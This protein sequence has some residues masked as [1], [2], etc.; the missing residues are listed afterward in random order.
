MVETAESGGSERAGDG[1]TRAEGLATAVAGAV[2]EAGRG[3]R[4]AAALC[5][6]APAAVIGCCSAAPPRGVLDEFELGLLA[7]AISHSAIET[8]ASTRP[9]EIA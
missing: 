5:S 9:D 3:D 1:G 6:G 8:T 4:A 2:A 7:H